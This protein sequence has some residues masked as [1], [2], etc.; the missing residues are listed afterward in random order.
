MT[1]TV[2]PLMGNL[3]STYAA[4]AGPHL[5]LCS[6]FDFNVYSYE[7]EV[8]V[9]MELWQ[10]RQTPADVTWARQRLRQG[11]NDLD[12][13]DG[14]L[15]ARADNNGRVRVLWECTVKE[16]LVSLGASFQLKSRDNMLGSIGF[17]I[18]YSN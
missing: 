15:K 7:S 4:K 8:A 11:W 18:S 2:N 3:S 13:V 5:A 9:G 10:L 14:V 16:L 17:E 6:Q 12:D 1:L